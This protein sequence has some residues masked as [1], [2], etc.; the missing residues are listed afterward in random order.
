MRVVLLLPT[1][2]VWAIPIL[3]RPDGVAA[4]AQ[5]TGDLTTRQMAC[6]LMASPKEEN[7]PG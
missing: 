2:R 3:L 6:A 5:L 1:F 4:A 7:P